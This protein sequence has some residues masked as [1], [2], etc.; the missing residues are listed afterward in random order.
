VF[1][2]LIIVFSSVLWCPPR[3]DCLVSETKL[4]QASHRATRQMGK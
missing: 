1:P 4:V 3:R 2:Q